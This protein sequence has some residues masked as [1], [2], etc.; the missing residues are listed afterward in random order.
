MGKQW[1]GQTMDK[2]WQGQ[3]MGKQWQGQTMIYKT[4]PRKDRATQTPLK[5]RGELIC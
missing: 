5:T 4:L 3:T 1:Q 2:Q